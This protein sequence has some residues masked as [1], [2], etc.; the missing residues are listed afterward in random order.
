[1]EQAG[2]PL[3]DLGQTAA[4]RPSIA[5]APTDLVTVV[6][7]NEARASGGLGPLL[8]ADGTPDPAGTMSTALY[9]AALEAGGGPVTAPGAPATP[10][11]P[12]APAGPVAGAPGAVDAGAEALGAEALDVPTPATDAAREAFAQRMTELQADRCRHNRVNACSICGVERLASVERAADGSLTYPIEWRAL[13]LSALA[14]VAASS[15]PKRGAVVRLAVRTL[16]AASSEELP[17]EFL[18]FARG[19]NATDKG[20]VIVDDAGI[21]ETLA[22]IGNRRLAIDLEH[23]SLDPRSTNYDPDA[24]GSFVVEERPGGLWATD[25]RWTEDGARRVLGRT[26]FY[27]SPAVRI[28]AANR[29]V[30]LINVGLVAQPATQQIAPLIAASALETQMDDETLL[31]LLRTLAGLKPE[32]TNDEIAAKITEKFTGQKPA[33]DKPAKPADPPAGADGAAPAPPM[34]VATAGALSGTAGADDV[35]AA[36]AMRAA[37]KVASNGEALAALAGATASVAQ[38]AALSATVGTLEADRVERERAQVIEAN[39]RKFSPS[40]RTWAATQTPA[41]LRAFAANAPDLTSEHLAPPPTGAAVV[42]TD[43][44]RKVARS[45]NITPEQLVAQRASGK[46]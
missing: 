13:P 3:V 6:S 38:V 28:D 5:L 19:V 45:F 33:E 26:Q 16:D 41:A 40:L 20:D 22:A 4:A 24:R 15:A 32:A 36:A 30:G 31:L 43:D 46:A 37:F 2:V 34:G 44:D 1:L 17:T 29:M 7:V 27:T 23:L 8:L 42:I 35:A 39:A 12:G 9:R 11:A 18:I 21:A 14:V 10:T 25:V